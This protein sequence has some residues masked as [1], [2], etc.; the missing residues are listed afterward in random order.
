MR[1]TSDALR[2]AGR[3]HVERVLRSTGRGT[4]VRVDTAERFRATSSSCV[5]SELAGRDLV[6]GRA[7]TATGTGGRPA[8]DSNRRGPCRPRR[9]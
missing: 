6:T 3:A 2:A 4:A 8:V 5:V 9:R 7:S 1:S